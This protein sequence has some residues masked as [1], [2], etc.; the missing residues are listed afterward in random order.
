M[1]NERPLGPFE[2]VQRRFDVLRR[3]YHA[4]RFGRALD[5]NDFIEVAFAP[6]DIVGHVEI[7]GAGPTIDR[8]PGRHLDIV[9]DALHALDAVRELAERRGDQ[10]LPLFLE[11]AHAAAIGLRGTADQDHGPAILLGIGETRETVH[12]AWAGD[13]DAGAGAAGEIAVGPCAA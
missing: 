2:Q 13:G 1:Q 9:G 3:R 11:C 12:H 6:D 10:H 7:G 4:R 5:L 8:V